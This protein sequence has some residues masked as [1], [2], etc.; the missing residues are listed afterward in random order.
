MIMPIQKLRLKNEL[1]T[2]RDEL[3]ETLLHSEIT[4]SERDVYEKWLQSVNRMI[5][6]CTERNKF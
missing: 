1:L 2:T 6:I 3:V 4:E 5:S